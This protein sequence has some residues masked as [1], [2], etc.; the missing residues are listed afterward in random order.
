MGR[1]CSIGEIDKNYFYIVL[2]ASITLGIGF[3]SMYFFKR[4]SNSGNIEGVEANK[5]LKT[6]A[7]YLGF[8]LCY[9]GEF[10]LQKHTKRKEDTKNDELIYF[11]KKRS[12]IMDYIFS[13]SK[14]KLNIKD[15]LYLL[16]ICLIILID[17]FM[18][19]I[20]KAKKN[21]GFIIFNEEYNSIEFFLLFI[22]SIF[23][24]KMRYYQHQHFS[25]ILIILLEIFRYLI[26]IFND[27]NFT[28]LFSVFIL[29]I[30]R[31]L[32]DCIFFGYIKGLMEYKY[33]SPFKCCYI[34]GFVNTPIIIFLYIILSHIS[35]KNTNLLCSLKYNDSYYFDNFYSIF[36]NI[37][38]VQISSFLLYTI[39]NGIYQ[40]LINITIGQFTI[41]HLFMP[42]QLTQLF[43]NIYE[44]FSNLKLMPMVI[45][46]GIF[47]IIFIFIF[48]E[49]IVLNFL[50][51]NKNIKKNI[52]N[53]AEEDVKISKEDERAN[54][55]ILINENYTY[56]TNFGEED[57]DSSHI[58]NEIN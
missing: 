53:R 48:L 18:I 31:S 11:D 30:I 45:I 52:E 25:I 40:L 57:N 56:D 49:V 34:F 16:L 6:L 24:F 3:I 43:I 37:N 17:D 42:C 1:Y 22:I 39:C 14:N 4:N 8:D 44:S 38:F 55:A 33:F 12:K 21:Q 47:E 35:F 28:F 36:K 54:S 15:L 5:L 58:K 46:S 32:S 19:I 41:C 7:R 10:I 20:I 29:Q 2:T 50:G 13:D 51:L 23:I 27:S 26:K 9:I